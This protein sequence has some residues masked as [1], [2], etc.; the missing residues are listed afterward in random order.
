M[1]QARAGSRGHAAARSRPRRAEEQPPRSRAEPGLQPPSLNPDPAPDP[2]PG[3]TDP[4]L[5]PG[6]SPGMHR[7]R[8][9]TR[10][11]PRDARNPN[12]DPEPP[13]GCTEP[14]P[15]PGP[16]PGMLCVGTPHPLLDCVEPGPSPTVSRRPPP[17]P[18]GPR[19]AQTLPFPSA[20]P[21]HPRGPGGARPGAGGVLGA[22]RRRRG[23][24]DEHRGGAGPRDGGG[25]GREQRQAEPAGRT[26]AASA[27]DERRGA[28]ASVPPPGPEGG[29][30]LIFM[31]G[32]G[33]DKHGNRL[34]RGK[35]YYDAYLTRCL[36]QQRGAKPY[37]MALAF[38]E[39]M[40]LQVPVD[41]HDVRVDE[42]LYEDSA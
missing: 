10:S 37:T 32:L 20:A 13:P 17:S 18:R 21:T 36:Q 22:G 38:R 39:Q 42:V 1:G 19:R 41:E 33:F 7:A 8:T 3:C 24:G 26:E 31:P 14:G 29:L 2:P 12:S 25:G 9:L 23:S 27:G 40:C 34:G 15:C 16:S 6:P 30:D 5:C 4:G 28:A 35:G 11:L